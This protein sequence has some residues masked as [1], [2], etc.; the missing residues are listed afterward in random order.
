MPLHKQR[1]AEDYWR[2]HSLV[3]QS[4][5]TYCA[6]RR[7]QTAAPQTRGTEDSRFSLSLSL[8]FCLAPQCVFSGQQTLAFWT[9]TQSRGSREAALQA[10]KKRE[11]V[12]DRRRSRR[13]DDVELVK[14]EYSPSGFLE[15]YA[16]CVCV[17]VCVISSF[18]T[19]SISQSSLTNS[20]APIAY[21][22]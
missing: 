6:P 2:I 17:C 21:F 7:A 16:V 13:S 8:S 1:L 15:K 20:N 11:G 12:E 10:E 22:S 4:Y 3:V 9:A 14:L 19:F 18:E 5:C